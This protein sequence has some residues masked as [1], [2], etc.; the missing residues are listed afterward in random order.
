MQR[1]LIW[2]TQTKKHKKLIEKL[3]W[4]KTTIGLVRVQYEKTISRQ[5]QSFNGWIIGG[6]SRYTK[7]TESNGKRHLT[8]N[9]WTEWTK[10]GYY[11]RLTSSELLSNDRLASVVASWDLGMP[12]LGGGGGGG[13]RRGGSSARLGSSNGGRDQETGGWGLLLCESWTRGGGASESPGWRGLSR[14]WELKKNVQTK[15]WSSEKLQK[16]RDS[17]DR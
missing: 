11:Y 16:R 12:V 6:T 10:N 14:V 13:D 7:A 5:K 1:G 17:K 9:N 4:D 8:K 2:F 3:K 15:N